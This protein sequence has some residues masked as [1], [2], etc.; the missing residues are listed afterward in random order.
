MNKLF[1]IILLLIA[2]HTLAQRITVTATVNDQE[3]LIGEQ[4]Q[5]TLKAEGRA[6]QNINWFEVKDI[7]HFE[8]LTRSKVD[9]TVNDHKKTLV[10]TIMLTSWDSGRWQIPAFSLHR[11]NRTKPIPIDV[12][13]TPVKRGQAYN[14]IKDILEVNRPGQVKWYWYL[15][16]G[17][18]LALL[19]L[20]L[21]PGKKKKKAVQ[22]S[23]DAYKKALRQL[24]GLNKK[25]L[26]GRDV[27]AYYTEL[28]DIFR[29]YL[30]HRKN[31]Q[32]FSKTT[33]DL[34]KQVGQL[35]LPGKDYQQLLE[36]LQLSDFV[37]FARYQP[38]PSENKTSY[39]VIKKSITTIENLK[40]EEKQEVKSVM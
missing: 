40:A 15:F 26:A 36:A 5:L 34:G 39:D 30:H 4:F 12:S 16:G 22:V 2:G 27:K 23:E 13:F 7:P 3:I 31:I 9:S 29:Q 14:D 17:L 18:M 10:Q 8:I 28:V 38:D 35:D 32:S 20:L 33:E 21:F 24:D 37:K 6:N 19:L 25:D 11:S 1:L